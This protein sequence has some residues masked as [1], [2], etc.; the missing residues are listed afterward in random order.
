MIASAD[1]QQA[2]FGHLRTNT[3]RAGAVTLSQFF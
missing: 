2:A 1:A 3:R